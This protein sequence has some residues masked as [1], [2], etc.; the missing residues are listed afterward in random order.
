MRRILLQ[1]A[2]VLAGVLTASADVIP[3]SWQ[4]F[5]FYKNPGADEFGQHP[6]ASGYTGNGETPNNTLNVLNNI[7]VGGPLGNQGYFS[8]YSL[9][10]GANVGANQGTKFEEPV[11]VGALTN[12]S[13]WGNF[14][15]TN[16][17]WVVE[18]WWLPAGDGA[19]GAAPIFSTGLNRNNRSPNAQSGV[20]LMAI[21]G[22]NGTVA[23]GSTVTDNSQNN[24]NS[25]VRLQAL[26]P[27]GA[28]DTNGNTMDFYIGP[29]VLVKTASNALWMHFAVVRD[30]LAGTV[31]WYTN[32]TL[33][34]SVPSWRV[35]QTNVFSSPGFAGIQ[36]S[37][38]T[39]NTVDAS[40]NLPV[41]L[42]A[43]AQTLRGY[44]AELRWSSF[45]PG[46]FYTSDLLTRRTGVGSTTVSTAPG[47]VQDPQSI[48][49]FAGASAPFR[50]NAA[51][52]SRITYQWLR[53]GIPIPGATSDTYVLPNAQVADSTSQ[54]NC[55]LT[56]PD[57][58]TTSGAALL[59]VVA[60]TVSLATGYSNAVVSEPSLVAYF[61]MDGSTGNTIKN[62]K[63]PA[64]SGTLYGAAFLNGD[65]N[66]VGGTQGLSLNS[67]N[68]GYF[69]GYNLTNGYGFAQIPGNNPGLQFPNGKGT[70]EAV[71]YMDPSAKF[72][73]AAEQPCFLSSVTVPGTFDYYQFRADYYGN[74]YYQ[75]SSQT[76]ALVWTLPT[77]LV[78]VRTHVAFTFDQ[79]AGVMTCYANGISLGT[80]L[81][82]G[83]GN[84]PTDSF[85][86]IWIGRRD[87]TPENGNNGGVAT[88]N[89]DGYFYNMWRGTID[90]V[91]IYGDALSANTIS[92]HNY[93][94][95]NGAANNPAS[96]ASISP[97]KTLYAGFAVQN[98]SVTAGGLAPFTYQWLA[99]NVAIPG[100]TDSSYAVTTLPV[101]T[102]NY[103]VRIQGAIG[104]PV[105][106][107]PITLNVV[108]P[109]D[110]AAKV[111]SSSGGPPVGYWPLNETGG[112]TV[113]DWAG[114]HDGVVSGG[115]QWDPGNGPVAGSTGSLRMFGTNALNDFSQVQIPYYPELNPVSGQ[116][117]W[118]FWYRLDSATASSCVM[119]SMFAV[120]NNKAGPSIYVGFGTTGFNQTTINNW[121]VVIGRYNNTNQ[122]V[123]QN[124]NGSGVSVPVT[125]SWYHICYVVN[126]QDGG[127]SSDY[128]FV[129]GALEYTDGTGYSSNPN[130]S[131]VWNQNLFAPLI[132]GNRNLGALPMF[133]ALSEV[134]IYNY[135]LTASDVTNHTSQIWGPAGFVTQANGDQLSPNA[136]QF[137]G[138]ITNGTALVVTNVAYGPI[139]SGYVL[140]A[141]GMTQGTKISGTPA[142]FNVVGTM[143]N[144]ILTVTKQPTNSLGQAISL[145]IGHKITGNNSAGNPII[146][147]Y[148]PGTTGGIGTYL[149]SV[150]GQSASIGVF[151]ANA[152]GVGVYTI[153]PAN[154]ISGAFTAYAGPQF[155][156]GVGSSL[157]L[158]A[159]AVLGLPNS[160]NWQLNGANLVP[161]NNFDGTPH[162]PRVGTAAGDSQGIFSP[163]LVI[164]ELTTNDTGFY[165][166]QVQNPLNANGVTNSVVIYL[167]VTNDVTK[168]TVT[169][170][171]PR[172][173]MTGG[174]I[175]DNLMV[176]NYQNQNSH[177]APYSVVEVKFSKRVDAVSSQNPANY[178][179]SGGVQ[180]TNAILANAVLDTK[181]G[182][183]FT[184]VGLQTTGLQP[185]TTYTV[186]VSNIK[187]E[188]TVPNVQAGIQT[189][190]FK[191]A[192]LTVGRA[193]WDYYYPISGGWAGLQAQTNS[194]FPFV[195]QAEGAVTNFSSDTIGYGLSLNNNSAFAGQAAN[196]VTT[197][198]AWVTP[199]N[200]G[201]YQFYINADD[202]AQLF[203]NWNGA[204]PNGA[205]PIGQSQGGGTVFNDAYVLGNPNGGDF[206][207]TAGQPY[208]LQAVQYQGGG[209]DFVRVGWRYLGT[210]DNQFDGSGANGAWTI[211]TAN[212]AP[213][214]GSSLSAYYVG[215]PTIGLQPQ[216]LIT[217]P[218]TGTTNLSVGQITTGTGVT[219]YQ[220]YLNG[221]S[222][223]KTTAAITLTGSGIYGNWYCA[224]DDGSGIEPTISATATVL[225]PT[226]TI[227]PLAASAAAPVGV[228]HN[229]TVTT[230][231]ASGSTSYQWRFNGLPLVKGA[232]IANP[233]SQTLTINSMRAGVNEGNYD[234]VVGDGFHSLT[235]NVQNLTIAANPSIGA[236]VSGSSLSL[237]FPSQVGPQYVLQYK[238]ALNSGTWTTLT[239]TNG[240]GAAITVP[241]PISSGNR[242]YRI[243]MQ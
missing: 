85:Q 3:Y 112:T 65:T 18:C 143:L 216:S 170:V 130:A 111:F 198:S 44:M 51:T 232:N 132:L 13:A 142:N 77:G 52:D 30:D 43:G 99:N 84:T 131:F 235:S 233:T 202:Q 184:T 151:T 71:I 179:I 159:G 207:L 209:S 113:F 158:N 190:T 106:S 149:L 152:G 38:I 194:C 37:G 39:D 110:Y 15:Q 129:N 206:Y 238:T 189:F 141:P 220:W 62:V 115:Y 73:F 17:N 169:S 5:D 224:V 217:M 91:A 108:N 137:S 25:Y 178:T 14:F 46:Q 40:G 94:L 16:A 27:V 157:T 32:G 118:E 70:I 97:S 193:V 239:T 153:S 93:R 60:Q 49:V 89:N 229:L 103:S 7:C 163:K 117:T 210:Q 107:A 116:F 34:A 228:P 196:Y 241:A 4:R 227:T 63:D 187:D 162:Y 54:F 75:S 125:N 160:Y 218:S 72:T 183:Q 11:P 205:Q 208:F 139:S 188:A 64:N 36:D 80:K 10:A 58:T 236:T 19:N 21:N 42:G 2:A 121:T 225:P 204:D 161:V 213:I 122:G 76:T 171:G 154:A 24:G 138:Y 66:K 86:P 180:I 68:M 61:P 67:P 185:N 105:T 123:G 199:T 96:V 114:T 33:V 95:N 50:V 156:E 181:F 20:C 83:L 53:G 215:A 164:T 231:A 177:Y 102:Y 221:V 166:L 88:I 223:G 48:T 243:Q 98:L 242:F 100:A 201:Y 173:V 35:Y 168:P 186:T 197:I 226:F 165:N 148:G 135:P 124:V 81:M 41:G 174:P 120:G 119:S 82:S 175:L 195:P 140:S 147:G 59:T 101:G 126:G 22:T 144:N 78:G 92:A 146:I 47:I 167:L 28:Q 127:P 211:P 56:T 155:T 203:F 133:G 9:K 219:N 222:Q 1:A 176:G 6:I 240:T 8:T 74:L 45:N 23:T 55:V 134:A 12:T 136:A 237:T 128:L 109:T 79:V 212:L 172:S 214:A 150:P 200:T 57:G 191:T 192:P 31:S 145:S 234:V 230:T 182:G 26:C 104:G 29:P 90:E 87:I 69:G